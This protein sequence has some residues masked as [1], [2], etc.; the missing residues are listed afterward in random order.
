M[1]RFKKK[2]GRKEEKQSNWSEE[3]KTA[4]IKGTYVASMT[5]PTPVGCRASVI[6]TAICLVNLSWTGGQIW[7]VLEQKSGREK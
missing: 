2:G 7:T 4:E 6:A 3:I 5:T 1:I